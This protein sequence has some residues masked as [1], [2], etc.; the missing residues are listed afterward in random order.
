[1]IVRESDFYFS[2]F[3]HSCS[4]FEI[5]MKIREWGGRENKTQEE[6]SNWRIYIDIY[7]T[8]K[9][10]IN[11]TKAKSEQ[12]SV[13][14]KDFLLQSVTFLCTSHHTEVSSCILGGNNLKTCNVAF[15]W[16]L[17]GPMRL[18]SLTIYLWLHSQKRD[19]ILLISL[20]LF[21]ITILIC[22]FFFDEIDCFTK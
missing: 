14:C 22:I 21:K 3:S 6:H 11:V 19:N 5:C 12:M 1:M 4:F 10:H 17:Q 9:S 16:I 7:H 8:L 18:C 2:L 13:F 20:R 15:K